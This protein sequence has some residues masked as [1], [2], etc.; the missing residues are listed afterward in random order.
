[1]GVIG[2]FL[3]L[4]GALVA[5][6]SAGAQVGWGFQLQS[7]AVVTVLALLMFAAGLNLTGLFEVG[8]SLQGV[9][10][11]LGARRGVAGAVFAGA[12]A[13]VVAA[14]C[15]APLMGP[16]I[17][18]ALTEPPAVA[19]ATFLALGTGLGLPLLLLSFAP[20]LFAWMPRPG[21]WMDHFRKA[22][23]FPMYGAAAWLTWVLSIQSANA[24]LPTLFAAAIAVAFA[25]WTWGLVQRSEGGRLARPITVVALLLAVPAA[26]SAARSSVDGNDEERSTGLQAETWSPQRVAELQAA[27]RP[28]F[29]DFTAAWCITCQVNEQLVLKSSRVADA[30]RRSGTVYLR[31]DWTN[32]NSEI[33]HALEMHGRSGVPLYLFYGRGKTTP[34][35]LP[36]ILT[37]AIVVGVL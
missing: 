9:G 5:A 35:V 27:G 12:L 31:A 16:A 13:A 10:S 17:G 3:L 11:S 20:R 25:G 19:M 21:R 23:A 14:P 33:S 26:V 8:G 34:K 6:R 32:R 30:F 18:W 24:A 36:Q 22:M 15:T 1:M 29:V 37:E 28:V 2:S 7:P 4:G